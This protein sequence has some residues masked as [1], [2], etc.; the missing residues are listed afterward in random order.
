MRQ[1]NTTGLCV[2]EKH[3][4]VDISGK[5]AQIEIMVDKGDYFTI[6]RGRQY[7]KTTTLNEL[8]KRLVDKYIC[9]LMSFEGRGTN[10]ETEAAFCHA[11]M[12]RMKNALGFSS[13]KEDREYIDRWMEETVTDFD[14][15]DELITTQCKG[16]HI[17]LMIDEADKSTN[18]HAYINFLGMLRDKYLRQQSGKDFT[19]QS[20]ILAGVYDIKNIKLKMIQQGKY[21]PQPNEGTSYNSP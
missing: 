13:I 7:G 16:K 21:T 12:R 1:F 5:L 18:Y 2:P 6:N 3:Y 4:M 10:F 20:V 17:V 19:F 8:E 9:A 11:F 15:L 14:A